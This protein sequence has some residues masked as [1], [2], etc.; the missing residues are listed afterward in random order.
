VQGVSTGK[1]HAAILTNSE[2]WERYAM[3]AGNSSGD[4]TF[5]IVF[6]PELHFS[7][8]NS[9]V[10]DMKN[11]AAVSASYISIFIIERFNSCS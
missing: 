6:A 3:T 9:A 2:E 7:E 1:Y 8:F 11:S 4:L 10:A 5:P